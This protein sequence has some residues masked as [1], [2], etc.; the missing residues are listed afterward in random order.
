MI[1][2]IFAVDKNNLIGRNND[3]PWHYP[4]D[5]KYF[6]EKTL[7]H[8]VLMGRKTFESIVNRLKKP[9]PK[10]QS[11]VFSR[12]GFQYEGVEVIEDLEAYL[13][14][15]KDEDIFV[16]GGK[17]VFE[18]AFPYA[19]RLYITHIDKE[20]MG[21]TYLKFDLEEFVKISEKQQGELN[22]AVY[23]RRDK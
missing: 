1:N 18:A 19:D 13:Q 16:I 15:I 12:H 9:L 6:Q 4:A 23:E 11:V 17:T 22:F 21:D 7:N 20:F 5:L 3:L 8:K 10:R 14:R 2:L